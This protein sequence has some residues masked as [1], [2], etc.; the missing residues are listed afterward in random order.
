MLRVVLD[1]NV[2]VSA[3]LSPNG[4]PAKI[5]DLVTDKKLNIYYSS[6]IL[7]EYIDVLN[8]PHFNFND[9]NRSDFIQNIQK[10]GILVT[11]PLS[12]IPLPDEDDRCF[13]DIAN[14]YEAI[15]VTGNMKHYPVKSFIV[16]PTEFLLFVNT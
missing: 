9:K 15:L 10:F 2:V 16:T 3:L 11:P 8:R 5:L 13:Y 7:S 12:D 14:F 4:N 1:T 6:E